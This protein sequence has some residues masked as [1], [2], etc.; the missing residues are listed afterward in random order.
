MKIQLKSAF[1]IVFLVTPFLAVAQTVKVGGEVATPLT[2]DAAEFAKYPQI[3][4]SRKDKEGKD[5]TYTG[6]AL[7]DILTKAGATMGD[8]LKG[9]NLTKCLLVDAA[10]NYQAV[11]ALA[12]LDKAFTECAVILTNTVDGKPLPKGDGPFRIIVQNEKKLGRCVRQVVQLKI[13]SAK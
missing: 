3:K 7:M 12:E 1:F 11:F 9:K 2:I 6:V 8:E 10:D 13:V 5:H 4:V